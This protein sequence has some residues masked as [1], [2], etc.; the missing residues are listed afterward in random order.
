ME[1]TGKSWGS[2]AQPSVLVLEVPKIPGRQKL[3]LAL[4]TFSKL[5]MS[6]REVYVPVISGVMSWGQLYNSPGSRGF[7]CSFDSP[8]TLTHPRQQTALFFE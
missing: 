6:V 1:H 8:E 3:V 4:T 7:H 5:S 2:P